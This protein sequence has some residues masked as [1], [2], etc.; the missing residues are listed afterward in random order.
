M[1]SATIEGHSH[2]FV[3]RLGDRVMLLL[4]VL[5]GGPVTP[6]TLWQR[7]KVE[8]VVLA[9]VVASAVL[10][11]VGIRRLWRRAGGGHVVSAWGV[12]AF[13]TGLAL[14]LVA[15]CSPLDALADTLFS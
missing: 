10:Y 7:W 13:Y 15:L 6:A 2:S 4:H 1:G 12:A 8:P 14:L 11:A 9:L 5:D 3:S